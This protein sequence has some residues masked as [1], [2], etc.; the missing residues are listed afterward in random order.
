VTE[1]AYQ[2]FFRQSVEN[3][4]TYLNEQL[5]PRALNPEALTRRR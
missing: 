5:P 3:I 2:V 4:E 1:E